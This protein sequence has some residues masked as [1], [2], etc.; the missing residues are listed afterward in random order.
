MVRD[1]V[2][3]VGS[4]FP[5]ICISTA[6]EGP[7]ENLTSTPTIHNVTFEWMPPSCPNGII[8]RYLFSITLGNEVTNRMLCANQTTVT[9][10]G[11]EP[12]E[13]YSVEVIASTFVDGNF[14]DSPPAVLT[15]FSLPDSE[16]ILPKI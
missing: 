11:L 14:S 15:G 5:I 3:H 12:Y 16:L 9:V 7:P 4:V 2:V 8:R 10:D 6:P 13:F 1:N